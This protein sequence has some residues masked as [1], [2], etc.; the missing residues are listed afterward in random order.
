MTVFHRAMEPSTFFSSQKTSTTMKRRRFLDGD[1]SGDESNAMDTDDLVDTSE[2][3]AAYDD[4]DFRVKNDLGAGLQD[5][6]L[7]LPE[8]LCNE[9]P[10]SRSSYSS[11]FRQS[12]V[13]AAKRHASAA[14]RARRQQRRQW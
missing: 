9:T 11:R 8:C 5:T 4:D 3:E 1:S 12:S 2:G 14:A 13:R 7:V 6:G 10:S